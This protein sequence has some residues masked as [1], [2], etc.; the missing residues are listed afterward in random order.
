MVR[1]LAVFFA[2]TTAA[3]AAAVVWLVAPQFLRASDQTRADQDIVFS[4][5]LFVGTKA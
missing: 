5:K 1:A 4:T 3:L 2:C